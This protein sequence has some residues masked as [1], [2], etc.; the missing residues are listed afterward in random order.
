MRTTVRL[1]DTLMKDVKRFAAERGES[2]TSIL[3]QAL[4]A[5]LVHH[6]SLRKR[7]RVSLPTFRGRGLQPGVSLDDKAALVELM[8]DDGASA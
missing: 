2:F 4:R 6:E 8:E 1:D 5:M 3:E 7:P